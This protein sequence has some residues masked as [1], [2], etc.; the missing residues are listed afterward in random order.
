MPLTA[1][2]EAKRTVSRYG[3]SEVSCRRAVRK[4][5]STC[6]TPIQAKTYIN[7]RCGTVASW[8][9][10]GFSPR[11]SLDP[12]RIGSAEA[13]RGLKPTLHFSTR[14]EHLW[15]KSRPLSSAPASWE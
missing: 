13:L 6:L 8:W 1:G 5:D 10:V 2:V 15:P 7:D 9:G 14:R 11:G 3:S 12:Q 4:K